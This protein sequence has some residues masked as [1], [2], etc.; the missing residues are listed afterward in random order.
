M[1]KGERS[2]L[3]IDHLTK[4]YGTKAAVDDLSLHIAPG[5][6]YGFIGQLKGIV[7]QIE[8]EVGHKVIVVATGGF[9]RYLEGAIYVN[10]ADVGFTLEG[11]RIACLLNS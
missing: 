2:M 3:R 9:S 11:A 7:D 5:E 4:H 1:E 10:R 8:K 6:I